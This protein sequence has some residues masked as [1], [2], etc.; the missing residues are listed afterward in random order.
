MQGEIREMNENRPGLGFGQNGHLRAPSDAVQLEDPAK[1]IQPA[2]FDA[3]LQHRV[4]PPLTNHQ[5]DEFLN[6][7]VKFLSF[8]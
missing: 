6:S 7:Q 2:T 3:L 4:I 8:R 5:I 1:R